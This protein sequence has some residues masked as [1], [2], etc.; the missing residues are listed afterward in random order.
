MQEGPS[1]VSTVTEEQP[2]TAK[3]SLMTLSAL[4][5]GSMVGAGVFSLPRRFAEETGVAGALIAWTIAGT[6]MLMLAFA[7]QSL[8][9][10]RPD[11]DAGVYAYAKAGFGEYLGFFSAFGYW[12][13]ACVGNVTY[14]VLIMSTIGTIWPALGDGDTVLAAALS[15]VGLWSFFLLIRRGVKE[16][17]A[18][19]R[20]VTVAKVV[21][22]L[23]FVVL[24]L[25]CLDPEVFAE[26]WGGADY[27]GS[28]FDQI[29]GTMLA[30]VFVFLGVEGASVYSRHARRRKDV[31]RAT[32]LGFLSVFAVFASV[33]I[34]SYGIMP[35]SEIAELRQPSM[36]GV[37]EHAVGT[38]GTVFVSVG[39]IVSVLGA[40]LAWS[41]M[42]AEVLYVAAQDHDMP[43][44][45]RRATA[46]DVPVPALVMT[47]V[48]V[49]LV[50]VVTLLSDDAFNFALN[51]TSS[52]TLIPFLLAAAFALKISLTADPLAQR[53]TT[54]RDLA[55]GVLATLYTAFLLYAAGLR[56]VLLSFIV[57]AP[58]T[59]LFV[60]ARR[61]QGR[62][63]F[64]PRELLI[65]A[66]SVAGA[67]LGV[68]ALAV[69]WISL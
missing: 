35:M 36:A 41:L 33:T 24:A 31:G 18:I 7:F 62:R 4:V 52:L 3:L 32:V 10:R 46:D 69:G 43:R 11:L 20:V 49:Q 40:Y 28:L 23:V 30:T 21:P 5:V 60:M 58:A 54:G 34:V 16:A 6:G 25:F 14:W 42:A 2:H 9:M 37:L 17:A 15:S 8:A 56:F 66:V 12:A 64:S 38:W 45:L 63:P 61:E 19:N 68:I 57:Y 44:F 53:P 26:N 48:L 65:C 50:L 13:S 39:L 27:A 59:I 47:T 29:R 67:A 51:M 1:S 55:I 22:I